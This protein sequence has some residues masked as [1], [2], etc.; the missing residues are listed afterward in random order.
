MGFLRSESHLEHW[1]L[2]AA[3]VRISGFVQGAGWNVTDGASVVFEYTLID[4]R[5]K[6]YVLRGRAG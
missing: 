6:E 4:A 5:C 2:F 1:K 3:P